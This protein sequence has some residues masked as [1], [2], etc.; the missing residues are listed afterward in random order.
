MKVPVFVSLCTYVTTPASREMEGDELFTFE[1]TD[2]WKNQI[3][4]QYVVFFLEDA[5]ITGLT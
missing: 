5:R 3:G 2:T 1:A 4:C